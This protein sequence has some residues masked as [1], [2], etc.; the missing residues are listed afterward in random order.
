MNSIFAENT[1]PYGKT[2]FWFTPPFAEIDTGG[3]KYILYTDTESAGTTLRYYYKYISITIIYF[4]HLDD[5]QQST[6]RPGGDIF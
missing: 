3:L 2:T 1:V 6:P 4:A 5:E